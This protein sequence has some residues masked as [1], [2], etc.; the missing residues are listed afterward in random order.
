[1]SSY[2]D[3]VLRQTLGE[4]NRKDGNGKGGVKSLLM[5]DRYIQTLR[6]SRMH[7]AALF[8][9]KERTLRHMFAI[10]LSPFI[11]FNALR[12]FLR[13]KLFCFSSLQKTP[14]Y[15]VHLRTTRMNSVD[16]KCLWW[17]AVRS[18]NIDRSTSSSSPVVNSSTKMASIVGLVSCSNGADR[19]SLSSWSPGSLVG[20]Q[21]TNPV[22][23]L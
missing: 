4:G 19:V 9:L 2:W 7:N 13:W 15:S 5:K 1:M 12:F 10:I 23:V 16:E 20:R 3:S 17:L 21:L 22:T 6:H 18:L 8:H 11:R 14:V